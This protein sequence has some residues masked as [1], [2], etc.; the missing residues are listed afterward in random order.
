M[1]AILDFK[2]AEKLAANKIISHNSAK[3]LK[4]IK[5]ISAA[6]PIFKGQTIRWR[7]IEFENTAAILDFNMADRRLLMRLF[8]TIAQK[9]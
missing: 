4:N 2:M 6:P 5:M 1:A 8:L 9:L 3:T 7:R